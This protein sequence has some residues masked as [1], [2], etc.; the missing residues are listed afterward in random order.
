MGGATV[1]W[2]AG[3]D[4]EVGVAVSTAGWGCACARTE[5]IARGAGAVLGRAVG[6]VVA[7]AGGAIT[8][9][10]AVGSGA[11]VV[12]VGAATG[13]SLSTGPAA[14]GVGEDAGGRR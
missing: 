2:I 11:G 3:C 12:V 1:G 5:G 14:V 7:G 8:G 13:W 10:A 4:V 6:T 9:G